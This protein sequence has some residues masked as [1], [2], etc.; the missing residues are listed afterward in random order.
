M[1]QGR[2]RSRGASFTGWSGY[3]L[4]TEYFWK[5]KWLHNNNYHEVIINDIIYTHRGHYCTVV[6]QG[7]IAQTIKMPHYLYPQGALLYVVEQGRI[8]QGH[9]NASLFIPTGGTIVCC[10]TGAHSSG[11]S[12]C[13]T[14]IK[15]NFSQS[16]QPHGW[17]LSGSAS[18]LVP[19]QLA[20]SR[21]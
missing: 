20:I 2:W 11:A 6:E 5:G 14:I 21:D 19:W 15:S 7:R 12:K 8:A 9:Q 3:L 1:Y 10:G 17:Y 13:H 18:F 4:G 16:L